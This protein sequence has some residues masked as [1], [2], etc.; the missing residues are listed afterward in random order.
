[1][2]AWETNPPRSSTIG[3]QHELALLWEQFELAVSGPS[4]A[5]SAGQIRVA[6]LAGEPGIGKTYLLNAMAARVARAG[7]TVLR[8]GASEAE[9][10]PP[11]LPFLEALGQHIQATPPDRL[12]EDAGPA[13]PILAGILP[14]LVTRL[15]Q[16]APSYSLPPEQARLRFYEAVGTFLT[17]ISVLP[18]PTGLLLVLDDL[19]WADVT[20]LDLLCHIV[21]RRPVARLLI[22]G[23]YRAGAGEQNPALARALYELTRLRA[24]TTIILGPLGPEEVTA[25][26]ADYL[27]GPV[28]PTVGQALHVHSEGNPFFVEELLRDWLETG[29]LARRQPVWTLVAPLASTLPPSIIGAIRQ[30]LARLDP[31]VVDQLRIAAIIGRAFTA[32]LLA[33]VQGGD[34]EDVEEL[35]LAAERARLVRGDEAGHFAFSHDKTRECLY[36]EVS[37]TRRRRLH[38][39][40]ALVLESQRNAEIP[41][42]LA[43]I[44]FH[45]AHSE[46]HARGVAY[47]HRAAKQALHGHAPAEA[48]THY[49][50]AIDLLDP[51]DRQRGDLL[52]GLGEAAL[53]AAAADR[54]A[55]AFE[56]AQDWF[57]Q[58]D[59]PAGMARAAHGRGLALWRLDELAAARKSLEHALALLDAT[60]G[61]GLEAEMVHLLVDLAN[62]LGVVLGCQGEALAH[63]RRA[64]ELA[65]QLGDERLAAAASR[66]LGFLLVR[67]NDLAAGL[68]LLERAL[69]AH[70]ASLHGDLAEAAECCANLAQAYCWSARFEQSRQVSL[71]REELARRGQHPYHLGY[72]YT[73]L[74]FLHAARGNWREAEQ[75]LAQAQPAAERLTS[76]EPLA[77]WHQVRGYLAYQ[78][79]QYAVAERECRAA[80]ATFREKHPGELVLCLG[81]LGLALLATGQRREALECLAEQETLL[82]TLSAGYLPTLSARG[83]LALVGVALGDAE[84]AA[85]H[86]PD[87]LACQGQHHWFLVDRILGQVA[88]LCGDWP[89]AETHL[90]A[91]E[92]LARREGLRP[93]LARVLAA[94]ADLA[95]AQGGPESAM[96]ARGLLG[97]ARAIFRELHVANQVRRIRRQLRV[98]PRQPGV[99]PCAPLPAGLSPREDQVLRLMAAGQS[100]RQI[101]DELALSES[102]V[103]KHVTAIL[104]KTGTDNR[105]AAAA[106][107]IHHG[108]A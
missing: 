11:Y 47:S 24:L 80:V 26:A 41:P 28:D 93:E 59:D 90:T 89:A 54:A 42:Q 23:A 86:Y 108:L 31:A 71:R 76:A 81:P 15:G 5:I 55:A 51:N 49:Q 73:W 77:F 83:C 69:D 48:M 60:P 19:H 34:V 102:T 104:N 6:L 72:V 94:Q 67:E 56:A 10:M 63:G 43:Q 39:Q 57:Q 65:H 38:E 92:A 88:F 46:D 45:F 78:Q 84:R 91:A 97:Q 1:M 64:L 17:A 22:L 99:P 85:R 103:A 101:A 74:A 100:N 52:L 30:R 62:L 37:S 29:A 27:G 18:N 95:L 98:L 12:R 16:L 40:I 106:F 2:V 35:L 36:T 53:L 25:L 7:A 105:T 96:Q 13:A 50:A 75:R 61:P 8:G 87:L 58:I 66:A 44:A 14:E 33:Q 68:P 21:R 3:R 20:S 4:L 70:A 9:G 32:S 79:G 107:A 82:A